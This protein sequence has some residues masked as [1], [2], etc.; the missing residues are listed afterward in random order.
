MTRRV[1]LFD[2]D[3]TLL[4]TDGA[5]SQAFSD[6]L[7]AR[8]GI[9]D[10]LAGIAFAGRTDPLILGDIL[11]RHEVVLDAAGVAAFWDATYL[12][13]TELLVPGRGRILPGVEAVLERVARE[14]GWTTALLTGNNGPMA[15]IKLRHYGIDRW[16]AFGA[17]GDEALDRNQLA[18]LAVSRAAERVGADA[19][20]C[21]VIGDTPLDIACARA[22]EAWAVAVATGS[23]GVAELAPHQPDL[24][25]AD[26]TDPE[27]LVAF[28]RDLPAREG[29][30]SS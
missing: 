17:F 7:F 8:H 28:V 25:L 26:L 10:D 5:G 21:V 9:R 29:R 2:I 6:V 3:G 14:P 24:L 20:D 12:R 15:Q 23:F 19:V 4:H 30:S 16:F 11:A 13:A 18:C 22:A 1:L 27:A